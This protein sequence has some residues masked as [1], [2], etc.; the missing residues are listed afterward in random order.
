MIPVD[1]QPS[2]EDV[3]Y[4][5]AVGSDSGRDLEQYLRDYPQYAAEL[6]DLSHELSRDVCEDEMP[7]SDK[8]LALID[9]AWLQHVGA[10]PQ[11]IVDPF[12]TLSVAEQRELAQSLDVPRQVITAFREHRVEPTSV[13]SPFLERLAAALNSTVEILKNAF[14]LPPKPDLARSYKADTRPD[15][16]AQVNFEQILLEADVPSDKRALLMA[17]EN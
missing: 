16:R 1:P 8:D 10:V 12:A 9:K 5:F 3:L 14:A 17:D 13:P 4:T 7:L 11:E 2:R 6:I 15:D